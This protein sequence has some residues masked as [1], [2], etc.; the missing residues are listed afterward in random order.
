MRAEDIIASRTVSKT[1]EVVDC[2]ISIPSP[3]MT[4]EP[5]TH[6]ERILISVRN[7]FKGSFETEIWRAIHPQRDC[8]M[9]KVQEDAFASLYTLSELSKTACMLFANHHFQ[10]AGQIKFCATSRIKGIF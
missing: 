10:E 5:M 4:P 6:S 2:S 9:T 1:P 8:K 7:Y 3:T